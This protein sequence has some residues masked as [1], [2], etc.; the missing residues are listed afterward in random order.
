MGSYNGKYGFDSFSHIKA[1]YYTGQSTDPSIRY[2][3]F[4]E[5]KVNLLHNIALIKTSTLKT[6]FFVLFAFGLISVT[7][8][9]GLFNRFKTM[10]KW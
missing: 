5:K 7:W 3:P 6:F 2:P 8:Y 10:A 1:I 9:Y 4:T